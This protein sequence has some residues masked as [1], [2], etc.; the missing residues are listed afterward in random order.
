M[1]A[2]CAEIYRAD[3][4]QLV[5]AGM[6]GG[7]GVPGSVPGHPAVFATTT[8]PGFGQV[9]TQRSNKKGKPAPCRARKTPDLC[10]HRVD[11]R[12]MARHT[13]GDHRLGQPLCPACYDYDHHAV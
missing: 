10:P 4:Y 5:A 1:C 2:S 3:A 9:H 12:C 7:K 11:L 6:K 8:A 13:D